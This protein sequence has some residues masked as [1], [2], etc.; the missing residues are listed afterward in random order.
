M[1][2]KRVKKFT[3]EG[4]GFPIT[5]IDVDVVKKRG[6]WT[7]AIDLNKFQKAVLLTLSH[8]RSAL[9][10]NEVYFIRTYFEMTSEDFGR[11]FGVTHPAVL[12]WERNKNQSAK[13]NP[14]TELCLRLLILE[15]LNI[16]N[17]VFRDTF[18]EFNMQTIAKEQ[19]APLLKEARPLIFS[20]RELTKTRHIGV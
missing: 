15:K 5:L 3:Y 4:L 7:L 12:K 16:N 18:R 13:M 10:G 2:K 19:K 8:K 9:T 11:Q 1:E 14:T 6:V 20:A 17:R